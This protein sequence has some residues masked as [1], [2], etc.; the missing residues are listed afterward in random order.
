MGFRI[1]NYLHSIHNIPYSKTTISFIYTLLDL[2]I[3][4]SKHNFKWKMNLLNYKHL[5]L[6]VNT[7]KKKVKDTLEI[8]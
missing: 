5:I 4:Y 2:A 1:E 6:W 8:Y 3:A 7:M